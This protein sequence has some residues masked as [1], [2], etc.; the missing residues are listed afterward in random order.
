M[1]F[2]SRLF[3]RKQPQESVPDEHA[4]IVSFDYGQTDLDALFEVEEHLRSAIEVAGVGEF[5]G[6][7]IAV[8]GSDGHLYMYGPDADRLFEVVRPILQEAD[9]LTNMRAQLRYGPPKDGV[10]EEEVQINRVH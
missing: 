4:V 8:D 1:G 7:D 3:G 6:N 2:W 10:R 5:D 9:C